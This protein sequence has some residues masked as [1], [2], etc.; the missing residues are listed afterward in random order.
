M[1][2][3]SMLRLTNSTSSSSDVAERSMPARAGILAPAIMSST[4][5]PPVIICSSTDEAA[6]DGGEEGAALVGVA[7]VNL[8]STPGA[9][10]K[11]NE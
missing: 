9:F 6:T 4:L 7:G 1:S 5:R 10:Y 3:P 2:I 8:T 11:S